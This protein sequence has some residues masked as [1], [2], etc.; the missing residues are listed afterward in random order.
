M[1]RTQIKAYVSILIPMFL[2]KFEMDVE[3]RFLIES[4]TTNV[5]FERQLTQVNTKV[6][7]VVDGFGELLVAVHTF[8]TGIFVGQHV[9]SNLSYNL[10]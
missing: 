2:V 9:H 8:E 5:T 3:V 1:N 6:L 7:I 4:T 10:K